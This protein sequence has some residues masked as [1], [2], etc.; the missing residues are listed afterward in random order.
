MSRYRGRPSQLSLVLAVTLVL[1]ASGCAS[2]DAPNADSTSGS[3]PRSA[4][5]TAAASPTTPPLAETPAADPTP[6]ATCDTVLTPEEYT[7]L[8]EDSLVLRDDPQP[9]DDVMIQMLAEGALG[10]QWAGQGDVMVWFAQQE[11]DDAGWQA[12]RDQLID[13]GYT[14]SNDPFPGTLL[15]PADTD[16]N[17]IPSVHYA[18][19]MLY[20]VS[21]SRFLNSVLALQ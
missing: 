21:Y 2:A 18:D 16:A 19:G 11:I 4:P 1:S 17:Y 9:F 6:A 7:S 20:F 3:T 8:A 15:A 5:T 13:D 12:R 14:E 10:C